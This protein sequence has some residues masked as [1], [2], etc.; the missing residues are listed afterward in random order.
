MTTHKRVSSSLKHGNSV[1]Q[2]KTAARP[3]ETK[4]KSKTAA[5]AVLSAVLVAAFDKSGFIAEQARGG[6]LG[7]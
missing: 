4:A 1:R 5:S 3:A 2:P 6:K 7:V